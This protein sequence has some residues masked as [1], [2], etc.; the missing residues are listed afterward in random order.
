MERSVSKQYNAVDIAK[1]IM[2]LLVVVIHKPL[3][4]SDQVFANYFLGKIIAAVAVPFFF[5]ASSFFFFRKLDGTK[6]DNKRFWKF[7]KRLFILYFAWSV[8]Y[9]PI[10]LIKFYGL[11]ISDITLDNFIVNMKMLLYRFFLS[12]TFI[13]L[14]Y[15]NTLMI[16]VA[17][18]FLLKKKLSSKQTFFVAVVLFLA[19][20]LAPMLFGILPLAETVWNMIPGVLS[21]V[22]GSEMGSGIF[23]A[24]L[25]MLFCDVNIKKRSTQYIAFLI[26]TAAMI[27]FSIFAFEKES[28]VVETVKFILVT[29]CAAAIFI[30]CRNT[31]LK[32]SKVYGVLREYSSMIYFSHLFMTTEFFDSFSKSTGIVAF[33]QIGVLKYSITLLASVVFSTIIILLS[34]KKPFKWLKYLY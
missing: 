7:E 32:D 10:N 2:A 23:C 15:I 29:I 24:G 28:I 12:Q 30:F 17:I 18:L 16:S 21:N 11:P 19:Y 34:R 31:D 6:E 9:F 22:F 27:S 20:K 1:L 13:H 4:S 14:W 26:S 3:F 33:F 25:G 8:F 5:I